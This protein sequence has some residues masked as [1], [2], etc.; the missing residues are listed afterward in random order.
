MVPGASRRSSS[1]STS[2]VLSTTFRPIFALC[3]A[4]SG[5][6]I[7][8]CPYSD[9]D[10]FILG[11]PQGGRETFIDASKRVSSI[12]TTMG[13]QGVGFQFCSG[14]HGARSSARGPGSGWPRR[15]AHQGRPTPPRPCG[16]A[17]SR[18]DARC[19]RRIHRLVQGG[20]LVADTDAARRR[21]LERLKSSLNNR[22]SMHP[23]PSAPLTRPCTSENEFYRPLSA[24]GEGATRRLRR[25][26]RLIDI[27][28]Q[29][30]RAGR[31]R[32]R[33]VPVMML[34]TNLL[35]DL[36]R[37]ALRR[38]QHSATRGRADRVEQPAPPRPSPPPSPTST[39]RIR[40]GQR[41]HGD[42]V[43]ARDRLRA[44]ADENGSASR[45]T[46]SPPRA[47]PPG[48]R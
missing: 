46:R 40:R 23:P 9:I 4:G 29:N 14:R 39:R 15:S 34:V 2:Q 21:G 6:R 42:P 33:S 27:R 35:A 32:P 48:S 28:Q 31:R 1:S 26:E 20:R 11:R 12:L 36:T 44:R 25:R 3:M 24:H 5:G 8:A 37:L 45:R 17:L 7:E 43:E 41:Q 47:S 38:A 16:S 18:R 30:R 22:A 13:G 10:A 19:L